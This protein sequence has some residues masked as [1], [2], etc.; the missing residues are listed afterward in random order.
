VGIGK[1][2]G[3][4]KEKPTVQGTAGIANGEKLSNYFKSTGCLAY[5]DLAIIHRIFSV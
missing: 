2:W 5:E 4:K 3:L 1:T